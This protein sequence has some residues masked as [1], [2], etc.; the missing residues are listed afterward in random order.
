MQG[1]NANYAPE[2]FFAVGEPQLAELREIF[3]KMVADFEGNTFHTV[4]TATA[5]SHPVPMHYFCYDPQV[6]KVFVGVDWGQTPITHKTIRKLLSDPPKLARCWAARQRFKQAFLCGAASRPLAVGCNTVW[7]VRRDVELPWVIPVDMSWFNP[8]A[9]DPA[10]ATPTEARQASRIELSNR[11]LHDPKFNAVVRAAARLDPFV[12]PSSRSLP[13]DHDTSLLGNWAEAET[14]LAFCRPLFTVEVAAVAGLGWSMFLSLPWDL[15]A[16]NQDR[17]VIPR[18]AVVATFHGEVRAIDAYAPERFARSLYQAPQDREGLRFSH[19]VTT[20]GGQPG[21]PAEGGVPGVGSAAFRANSTCVPGA[22]GWFATAPNKLF[23]VQDDGEGGVTFRSRAGT[24]VVEDSPELF[25]YT[26]ITASLDITGR[27]VADCHAR[28]AAALP[29]GQFADG[30]TACKVPVEFPYRTAVNAQRRGAEPCLCLSRC[31]ALPPAERSAVS[32]VSAPLPRPP[33]PSVPAAP[34]AKRSH[35]KGGGR[36]AEGGGP[37]AE[38]V[39]APPKAAP[40]PPPAKRSHQ[41]GGG[42]K[43]EA[44]APLWARAA[45]ACCLQ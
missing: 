29:A 39:A 28:L 8:A 19:L 43:A 44:A 10:I 31:M 5:G 13:P 32:F 20:V 38:A 25:R 18:G 40:Q 35:K 45:Q 11:V 30:A 9:I 2:L 1:G 4:N 3:R 34:P 7:I 15:V 12:V 14:A 16:R 37:K 42:Q 41:K 24:R 6:W 36:K 23:S 17:I 33:P 22:T 21:P 27:M 26:T